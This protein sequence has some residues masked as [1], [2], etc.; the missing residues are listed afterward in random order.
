MTAETILTRELTE[1]FEHTAKELNTKVFEIKIREA[2]A[3]KEAQALRTD[4]LEYQPKA[5]VTED[6]IKFIEELEL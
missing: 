1:I 5:K 3:I 6:V 4:L 2:I